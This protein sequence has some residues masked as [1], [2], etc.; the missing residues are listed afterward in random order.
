MFFDGGKRQTCEVKLSRTNTPLH[1]LATLNDVTYVEAAR[2]MA[3]RLYRDAPSSD[4]AKIKLA[5]RLATSRLPSNT[6]QTRLLDRLA[7]LT[8]H[9]QKEESAAHDLVSIGDSVRDESLP[10]AEH[11]AYTCICLLILN[12][13]ETLTN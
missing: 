7:T 12:L 10:A 1:A 9:Y 3:E 8:K 2:V 6:E 13:D 4:L 5:F 11:A